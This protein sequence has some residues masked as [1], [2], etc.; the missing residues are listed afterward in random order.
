MQ[1]LFVNTAGMYGEMQGLVGSTMPE[2]KGLELNGQNQL[3]EK[4][5]SENSLF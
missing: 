3:N 1:R 4:N 5:K 2:I